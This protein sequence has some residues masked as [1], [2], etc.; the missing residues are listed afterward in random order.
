[1]TD[2]TRTAY[3]AVAAQY[4][5]QFAHEL[6]HKPLDRALLA[7][8]AELVEPRGI[9]ADIGCGPGHVAAQLRSLEARSSVWIFL[10]R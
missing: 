5:K 7:A 8:F 3:D 10:R 6:D 4:E 9:I 1:M 2:A